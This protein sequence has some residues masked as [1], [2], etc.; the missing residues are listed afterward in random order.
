[1]QV[2]K[3][4]AIIASLSTTI[5]TRVAIGDASNFGICRK[6]FPARFAFGRRR[7][8]WSSLILLALFGSFGLVTA[9]AFLPPPSAISLS[10]LS[11]SAEIQRLLAP[12]TISMAT[13]QRLLGAFEAA[14]EDSKPNNDC[15]P[16]SGCSNDLSRNAAN[17]SHGD[18]LKTPVRLKSGTKAQSKT[19]I[20]NFL[21]RWMRMVEITD[22]TPKRQD[23]VSWDDYFLGIA[24][25]SSQRS[26]DPDDA[27]GACIADSS[28]RIVAIGYSGLPRGCPDTIFPW[29][30]DFGVDEGED[31]GNGD[32]NGNGDETHNRYLGSKNP[33]LCTAATN[34]VLNKGSQELSGCRLYVTNFPKSDD[35]KVMIQSGIR[36]LIVLQE[37][38]TPPRHGVDALGDGGIDLSGLADDEQDEYA[39]NAMLI[40]A[41]ID[42][43]YH[44]PRQSSIDL[45]FCGSDAPN[46][47][48]LRADGDDHAVPSAEE[49]EAAA[50]LKEE[51]GYDALSVGYGNNG[52]REDYLSWEDYFMSVALLTAQR[53]K[54]PSTQVGACIVD[55]QRR[56]VGLGYNGMPSGLHDDHMPWGKLNNY[57]VHN[58]YMYVTHAE[59]NAILNS[60]GSYSSHVNGGTLYV[61][62]FPCEHCTK[63][64]IQSGIKKVVYLEDKYHDTD[65]CR[66]SRAMLRC[67]KIEVQEHKRR[68]P[69]VNIAFYKEEEQT[70]DGN[71]HY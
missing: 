68:V 19:S 61:T 63:K 65:G 13:P 27:E 50:I 15:D 8:I 1:M 12:L 54:D 52:R 69:R 64:V 25:L 3:E 11:K 5:D 55:D 9:S 24:V 34:A 67:A 32:G 4:T 20:R 10:I 38:K 26:K 23:Y 35:V 46:P 30:G 49:I 18:T 33:Y 51:T 37:S 42:I 22:E 60:K 56:I 41:G 48:L 28:N 70:G 6:R 66:A 39:S 59:V 40:M 36:E 2:R 62:L 7:I 57:E 47:S 21:P 29:R 31:D 44:R 16:S 71:G 53:S 45:E 14:S 17:H 58:K 43:R